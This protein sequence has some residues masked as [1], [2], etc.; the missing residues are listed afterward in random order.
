MN[1]PAAFYRYIRNHLDVNRSGTPVA[2]DALAWNDTTKVFDIQAVQG[3][4]FPTVNLYG[5]RPFWRTDLI[6]RQY[7]Y[8]DDSSKWLGH[9][10]TMLYTFNGA[11]ATGSVFFAGRVSVNNSRGPMLTDQRTLIGM[12]C[13]N[14]GSYT[15][16][17]TLYRGAT[18]TGQSVLA[19]ASQDAKD[20][21]FDH[22]IDTT[23]PVG[24]RCRG[25]SRV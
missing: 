10:E 18:A 23:L 17:V 7:W 8:N 19:A 25:C 12:E 3:T 4:A 20:M 24:V 15:G 11:M 9:T 2:G 13:R 21:T 1:P 6:Q 5:G 14:N 22:E 16:T